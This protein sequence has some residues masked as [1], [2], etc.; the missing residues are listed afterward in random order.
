MDKYSV[1]YKALELA[2]KD[3]EIVN[4]PNRA[5]LNY[6]MSHYINKAEVELS[7]LDRYKPNNSPSNEVGSVSVVSDTDDIHEP[8]NYATETLLKVCTKFKEVCD[9]IFNEPDD[10]NLNYYKSDYLSVCDRIM[11]SCRSA[12]LNKSIS[13]TTLVDVI[14]EV[15]DLFQCVHYRITSA[16]SQ[17]DSSV[18]SMTS[19][20]IHE[21]NLILNSFNEI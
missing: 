9:A 14:S 4:N 6:I 10:Y 11:S 18:I 19:G 12:K 13:K 3:L 8:N 21:L 20:Y 2:C 15:I 5:P 17:F 7:V 1:I 16:K